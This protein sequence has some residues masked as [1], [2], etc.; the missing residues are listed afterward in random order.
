MILGS[1]TGSM[2]YQDHCNSTYDNS[3]ESNHISKIRCSDLIV[4]V[5]VAVAVYV[6]G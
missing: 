2:V 4:A 1:D 3:V 6:Y 5:A